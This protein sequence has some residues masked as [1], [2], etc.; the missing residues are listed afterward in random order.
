MVSLQKYRGYPAVLEPSAGGMLQ[1]LQLTKS[2]F[3]I[4]IIIIIIIIF[5]YLRKNA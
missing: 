1:T 2:L 5:Y 3:I 4:I